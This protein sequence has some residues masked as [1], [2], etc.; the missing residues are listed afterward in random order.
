M[1]QPDL[2]LKKALRC[3]DRDVAEGADMLMVKPAGAYLGKLPYGRV[4]IL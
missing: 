1:D 3:T 2:K 4:P